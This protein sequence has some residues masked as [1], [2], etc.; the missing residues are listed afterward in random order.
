MYH[1][2]GWL[3]LKIMRLFFAFELFSLC[4]TGCKSANYKAVNVDLYCLIVLLVI[5]SVPKHTV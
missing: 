4:F 3:R 1:G 5:G 2:E